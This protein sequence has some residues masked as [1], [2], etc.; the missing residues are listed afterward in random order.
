VFKELSLQLKHVQN[1]YLEIVVILWLPLPIG[2]AWGP[3]KIENMPIA[4]R[5][6]RAAGPPLRRAGLAYPPSRMWVDLYKIF[7]I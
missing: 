5:G 1:E 7:Y 3:E 2:L 4:P 6:G